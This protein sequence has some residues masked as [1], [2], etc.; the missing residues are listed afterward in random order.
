MTSYSTAY[1]RVSPPP[2]LLCKILIFFFFSTTMVFLQD[3]QI[4]ARR[5]WKLPYLMLYSCT[6]TKIEENRSAVHEK[7]MPAAR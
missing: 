7:V 2:V 4:Y 6:S 5:Q 1:S 3:V